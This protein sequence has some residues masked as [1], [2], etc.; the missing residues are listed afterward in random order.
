[1][2]FRRFLFCCFFVFLTIGILSDMIHTIRLV[3]SCAK[4]TSMTGSVRFPV[5]ILVKQAAE[6][7]SFVR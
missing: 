6:T 2:T 4:S 5:E 3:S 1:M 7:A